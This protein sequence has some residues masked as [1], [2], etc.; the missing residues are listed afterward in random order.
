M[1]ALI[2]NEGETILES[3][4]IEGIDWKTG[5]PLTNPVWAGG[6]YRL[7]DNYVEVADGAIYDV[8]VYPEPEDDAPV[9]A[10]DTIVIDGKKYSK[11]ELRSLL[12]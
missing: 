12:E 2:R 9:P 6:P 1:K 8:A 3:D 7:V 4:G 5:M 10:A 11:E